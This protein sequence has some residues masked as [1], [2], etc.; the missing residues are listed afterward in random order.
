M[1][2]QTVFS[3]CS[4]TNLACSVVVSPT[5]SEYF[6]FFILETQALK[7]SSQTWATV[8]SVKPADCPSS[9]LG[10]FLP[11]L[12]T[13]TG[14]G[15]GWE[16]Y[17]GRYY[18]AIVGNFVTV[19]YLLYHLFQCAWWTILSHQSRKSSLSFQKQGSSPA[20][21]SLWWPSRSLRG[22]QNS[23]LGHKGDAAFLTM[24]GCLL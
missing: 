7:L 23:L 3:C 17:P 2:G 8:G 18:S 24:E 14:C 1:Q 11:H 15:C 13:P 4:A 21:W 9:I 22:P 6:F 16:K 5:A 10:D 20:I 12:S 19:S